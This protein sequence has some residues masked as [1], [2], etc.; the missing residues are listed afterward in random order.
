MIDPHFVYVAAVLAFVFTTNYVLE[1]WRGNTQPHRVTWG[2]WALEGILAFC[3]EVQQHVGLAAVMTLALGL[4]PC[5]VLAASFH[6]PRAVWQID[7]VDIVCGVVSL[8]GLV[9]WALVHQS[10]V[11]IV[12][13][14]AADFIAALPTLR[15]SWSSPESESVSAYL[16]GI[17]N[18]GITLLTLREITTAGALFPGSILVTDALL[19]L[20]LLTKIGPR[21]ARRRALA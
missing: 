6:N 2:L 19:T 17:V 11:A 3:V 20:L 12:S 18:C 9:F 10:T 5:V 16:S 14:A 15:K 13:F 1:T 7:R 21:T 4:V 8:A